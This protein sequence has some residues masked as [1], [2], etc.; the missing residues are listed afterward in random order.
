LI[1]VLAATVLSAG[2]SGGGGDDDEKPA[3]KPP[4]PPVG[5]VPPSGGTLF[6]AH[7]EGDT[8]AETI[9]D[10]ETLEE[11]LGRKLDIDHNFYPW[12]KEFPGEIERWNIDQGRLPMISWNGRDAFASDIAAGKHDPLIQ[13]RA[14]RVKNLEAPVLI[15]WFWEMDG[16]KKREWAESPEAYI[17]AW[18]HIH[19]VFV[20]QGAT[21]V[22]WVWCPNASAFEDGEAQQFY[23]GPEY[24]DW[25]CADGYNWAPGR[26]GDEWETFKQ[27]F[28]GFYAW[29]AEQG[30][31]IMVGE[32][33]VQ[34]REPGERAAWLAD[35]AA[36][37]KADF[38][39]MRAVVYF[40][41]NQDYPWRI[42]GG[43]SLEAFKAVAGDP[44]FNN[45]LALEDLAEFAG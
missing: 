42:D 8:D 10:V 6:G 23:P 4:K 3:A 35:M 26:D 37:I 2:C 12:D 14:V 21:N 43:E 45:A 17:A 13:D 25:I 20:E 11:S 16:K 38:P 44:W 29:A 9:A 5:S 39:L 40:N 7:S 31:P 41:V 33:G 22:A 1:S 15:R 19:D 34:E 36:T 32:Y 24:V 28:S 27:I 30:K 18:R